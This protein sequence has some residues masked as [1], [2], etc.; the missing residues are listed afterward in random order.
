ML[1]YVCQISIKWN[2]SNISSTN[3]VNCMLSAL[4]PAPSEVRDIVVDSAQALS[5]R[6]IF[7][8]ASWREPSTLNGVLAYYT[9][10]LTSAPIQEIFSSSV[11]SACI[12]ISVSLS[13][14]SMTIHALN[15]LL[16]S[17]M[18]L[19]VLLYS[20]YSLFLCYSFSINNTY[21]CL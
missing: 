15:D 9:I 10:C 3:P 21:P 19:V 13:Y 1:L 14:H 20:K 7:V 2:Q 18:K 11:Q 4:S 12:N 17:I 5:D 16:F 8:N 6:D